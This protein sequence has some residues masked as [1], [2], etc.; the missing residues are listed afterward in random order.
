MT[1]IARSLVGL[2]IVAFALCPP[3]AVAQTT[4]YDFRQH[5]DLSRPKTFAFKNT[6]SARPDTIGQT[7]TYDSPCVDE[8]TNIAITKELERRGW[9]RD[10]DS[11]DVYVVTH[12]T[13][14]TEYRT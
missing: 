7:T 3:T 8:G 6:P 4:S 13:F 14:K 10:D 11:P 5:S 1:R 9:R 12:R 2:A